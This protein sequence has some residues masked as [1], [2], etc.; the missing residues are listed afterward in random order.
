LYRCSPTCRAFSGNVAPRSLVANDG[1]DT[2]KELDAVASLKAGLS[3]TDGVLLYPEGT[4]FSKAKRARAL[5]RLKDDPLAFQR[6]SRL[7]HL[8]P[9]RPGGA[10]ALL[11]AA[12]ACDVLFVGHTGLEGFSTFKEIWSG[13]LVNRTVHIRFWRE[14]A[15][16][17]PATRDERLAWLQHHWER[18]DDWLSKTEPVAEPLRATG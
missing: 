1:T 10:L 12:P 3:T 13:D 14:A 7:E 15:A 18:M 6:A 11:D 8:L 2:T 5:D 16:T 17:I 9:P 4:R